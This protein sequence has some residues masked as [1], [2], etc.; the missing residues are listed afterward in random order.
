MYKILIFLILINGSITPLLSQEIFN[1]DKFLEERNNINRNGMYILGGWAIAN[2]ISGTV[3]NYSS[4]GKTKYFHQFNA[5]WNTVNLGIAV[6]GLTGISADPLSLSESFSEFNSLQNLLLLNAALDVAY[7]VS[8]FYLK[9]RSKNAGSKNNL[10]IG[11][12]NSLIMQGS[13][14]LA[15]DLVLYFLHKNNSVINLF[16]LLN[17]ADT[18]FLGIQFQIKV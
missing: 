2:I 8:G 17:L 16:P 12:G 5:V 13:F 1:T 3:G 6:F 4:S 9:E 10:L 15:F 18:S 14:L 7:I 11:Y